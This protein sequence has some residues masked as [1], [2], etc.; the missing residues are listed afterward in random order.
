MPPP[1][2]QITA[3]MPD[4]SVVK[5]MIVRISLRTGSPVFDEDLEQEALLRI[6][7]ALR[8]TDQI[9]HPKAFVA[10]I[11]KDTLATHWRNRR[12]FEQID[13]IPEHFFSIT[14]E[15]EEKIDERRTVL[16]L[17]RALARLS[18]AKRE[19]IELFYF[20]EYSVPEIARLHRSSA[21]AVKMTLLRAREDLRRILH[22]QSA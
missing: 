12:Q 5:G 22:L 10:K 20:S 17:C 21:S 4:R 9:E 14:P 18:P 19:T 2:Q 7:Q 8:R 13:S 16:R 11:I 3:I 15:S 1:A 6:W